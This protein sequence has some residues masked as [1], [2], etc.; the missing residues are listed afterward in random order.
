MTSV[1]GRVFEA[2]VPGIG[3]GARYRFVLDGQELNDP[4]ARF[5]PD[6][7]ARRRDGLAVAPPLAATSTSIR[8]LREHVIYEL[9]VGTFTRE[10][11]YAAA[12]EQLD[13]LVELGVTAIELMPV[14]A[15]PAARGWGY[16][17]VA[18]LRAAR[19]A[20][21]RPTT[22]ARSSTRRTRAASPCC[23]TSSTTTSARP[24]TTSARTAPSTSRATRRPPGATRPTSRQPCDAPL[25]LDNARYWLDGLPASTA[26]A[27]TRRTR[28]STRRRATSCASSP[29]LARDALAAARS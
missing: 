12:A 28:S 8:P 29:T 5:L 14:A 6:G 7:I 13:E 3:H 19:A 20:T 18:L 21:A 24:G 1:G 2:R 23:S 22:C 17:G 4:Y 26:C 11:T 15:S 25:V 9:H 16:D 27:S 10:G